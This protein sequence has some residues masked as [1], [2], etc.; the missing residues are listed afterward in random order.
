MT[1]FTPPESQ[2][3]EEQAQTILK[4]LLHKEGN[5]I[6]WGKACQQLQKAGYNPPVI[7]EATG[8][9]GSQQN[10]VIVASQVYESLVKGGATEDILAYYQNPRS[11]VLYAFRI[12]NQDQRIAAAKLAMQKNLDVDFANEVAKALKEFAFR[13]T[14]MSDDFP[15]YPGDAVAYR[16]WK[17]AKEKKDL[18]ARS[19][20]I[21]KALQFAV[22]A[23]ARKQI[24]HLLT[25][26]AVASQREAPLLPVYRLEAEEDLPRL[27]PLAG[28]MPLTRTQ[29]ESLPKLEIQEPFRMTQVQTNTTIVPFPGWQVVLKADNP[30]AFLILSEQLPNTRTVGE[31]VLV[32]VDREA[33]AWDGK[34]YFLIERDNQLEIAWLPEQGDE[35]ILGQVTV[36]VRPKKIVDEGNITE[37]WQ[38]DD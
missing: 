20:L 8:F 28:K 29:V 34:S 36:I 27:V 19:R 21:G 35:T 12:L 17:Q 15:D 31:E 18:T 38:M 24:E 11:D 7:F 16:Y 30:I 25:D 5:W 9:Q 3:S 33:K 13:S 4:S 32:L 14:E 6:D 1:E 2:L 10:L 23:S 37:P 26:F 22:S